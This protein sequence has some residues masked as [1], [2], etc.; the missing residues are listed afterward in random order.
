MLP[1]SLLPTLLPKAQFRAVV[2][3]GFGVDLFPLVEPP[4]PLSAQDDDPSRSAH[5]QTKAL[6]P[7]AGRKMIDWG[8]ERVEQ[9]GVFDILVLTPA[10]ISKPMAHHLRARRSTPSSSTNPTA[11]VELE[12][13]PEDVASRGTV[14]VLMWAAE[15]KL[16]TTDFILLPCDL[17]LSPATSATS[18]ISLASLL[19]RH[20]TDD[21]LITTLFSTR[22]SGNVQEARKDGPADILTIWDEATDRL[23]DV[24]EMDEFDHDEVPLRTSLLTKYS[25][26]TL[27]T[28]LLPTE[29]YIFS[30]LLLPFLTSQDPATVRRLKHFESI[31]DLTGWVA[32]SH[33]RKRGTQDL[34]RGTTSSSANLQN[35][36]ALGRSTT[37]TPTYYPVSTGAFEDHARSEPQTPGTTTPALVSRT[38]WLS[39]RNQHAFA[40]DVVS[41]GSAN[42]A[43]RRSGAGG[44][45]VVVWK[46]EDGFC[47]RGNTVN[48]WVELN[49]AA[50]KL[51]PPQPAP[52]STPPG[53]FISPDSFLNPTVYEK[54]GEKVG[55]KRCIIGKSTTI[56]KGSKLT[57]SVIM[58]NVVI[59]ENVKLD[60]CVVSNGVQIRDRAVLKDCE[61]GRDV[62]VDFDSQL[63]GEQLTV[64]DE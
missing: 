1:N 57:N 25:S 10:S 51:L 36:L 14:R 22:A 35:E 17:L 49:R 44:C 56:G 31:R 50:L 26:P 59:G 37:Q 32:R 29:L 62:I 39:N 23:L 12:E 48:G 15:H 24:R 11:K 5:G 43:Q 8:L 55:I 60:N 41:N 33:W 2:L 47:A 19:D 58:E 21:N 45:K 61:F 38:S 46:D 7:V 52:T 28:S 30:A 18:T 13:I 63:K 16:I 6:L 42:L 54:L 34:S 4:T 53:V 40:N 27:T 20:R 64:G 3:C 9:A